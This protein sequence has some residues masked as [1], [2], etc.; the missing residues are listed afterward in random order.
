[1][2]P[3]FLISYAAISAVEGTSHGVDLPPPLIEQAKEV[4]HDAVPTDDGTIVGEP[5]HEPCVGGQPCRLASF[6][7]PAV[8]FDTHADAGPMCLFAH[9]LPPDRFRQCCQKRFSVFSDTSSL[10][11]PK[12]Q[13][14]EYPGIKSSCKIFKAKGVQ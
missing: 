5:L 3:S 4:R 1:M 12:K 13:R 8:F 10:P 14:G 11:L 2:N 6:H 9:K 7:E